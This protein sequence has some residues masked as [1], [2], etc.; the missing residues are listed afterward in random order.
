MTTQHDPFQHTDPLGEALHSLRMRG[1][2]YC[3][4]EVTAP[5]GAEMPAM[6]DVL[7]FHLVTSG[8][9]LIEVG[10]EEPLRLERGDL[11]VL[12]R[13]AGHLIRSDADAE[14]PLIFDL[15]HDYITDQYAILRYDGGGEP[16]RLVCGAVQ[17]DH[18][19]ARHLIDELPP[20]VVVR[21]TDPAQSDWV[22]GTMR[23]LG[24]E[25]EQRRPGGEAIVTRLCDV[26][27]I[28]AVRTWI[29]RNPAGNAG[30]LG[31]LQD[32]QIGRVVALI[33][34][35]PTRPWTVESL[36]AEAAMSRSA[37]AARF[38]ELVGESPMQ[39]VT[40]WRMHLA[41]DH[42]RDPSAP[43]VAEVGLR[44]GY[45]SEAAF[46]RAFKR[47]L[48]ESPGRYRQRETTSPVE[49]WAVAG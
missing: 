2:F 10:D 5:W 26:V 44:L 49:T 19:A 34:R 46:S 7:F 1:A 40:R 39:Y 30:W 3:P 28:H 25:A 43:S 15:P 13:G 37:F 16:S 14:T 9:C 17:F 18:P 27:V 32:P 12:P 33:N 31:A 48:G 45:Q 36:A 8:H 4:T 38:T 20:V 22:N 35:E 42:L 47:V 24:T 6:P 11:A 29:E 21:A 41:V 23:L